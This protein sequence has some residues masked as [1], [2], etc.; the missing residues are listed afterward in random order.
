MPGE[1]KLNLSPRV[2]SELPKAVTDPVSGREEGIHHPPFNLSGFYE[3][4][5]HF[6]FMPPLQRTVLKQLHASHFPYKLALCE[7]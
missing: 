6:Y 3:C 2:E 7:S 1:G 4:K 5:A